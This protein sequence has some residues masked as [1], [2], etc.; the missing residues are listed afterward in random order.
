MRPASLDSTASHAAAAQ[1]T[2]LHLC[3]LRAAV[4]SSPCRVPASCV[5]D[6]TPSLAP[7][8]RR[9]ARQKQHN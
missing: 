8:S 2:L 6:P 4:L 5:L 9:A 3:R 7:R 1:L